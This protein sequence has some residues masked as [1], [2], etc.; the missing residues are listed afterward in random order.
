LKQIPGNDTVCVYVFL[1]L[2]IVDVKVDNNK[3]LKTTEVM[4][5]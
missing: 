1:L 2:G 5:S 4:H 3:T